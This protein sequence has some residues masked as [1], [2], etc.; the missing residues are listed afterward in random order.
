VV[1]I[2]HSRFQAENRKIARE[3]MLERLDELYNGEMSIAN[4]KKRLMELKS[5]KFSSKKFKLAELKQ[6]WKEREGIS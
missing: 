5:K 1:K 4:Q 3:T 2:H 6:A